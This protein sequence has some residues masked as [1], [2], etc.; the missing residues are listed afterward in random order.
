M[1]Y[2]KVARLSFKCSRGDTYQ[3]LMNIFQ[4]FSLVIV[5]KAEVYQITQERGTTVSVCSPLENTVEAP[6][7]FGT[8]YSPVQLDD[9][10]K[11]T[12]EFIK[13]ML[14]V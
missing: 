4:R 10:P 11:H 8:A 7:R 13:S 6:S 12:A 3:D 2:F 14:T 1:F 5:R 9:D